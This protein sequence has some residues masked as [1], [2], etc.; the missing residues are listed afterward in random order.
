[1]RSFLS[2]MLVFL[3]AGLLAQEVFKHDLTGKG[4]MPFDRMDRYTGNSRFFVLDID[5]SIQNHDRIQR[6]VDHVCSRDAHHPHS[7]HTS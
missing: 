4:G 6:R 7:D 5:D 3:G 2:L 1:M